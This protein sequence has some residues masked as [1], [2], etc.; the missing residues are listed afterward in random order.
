VLQLNAF[1]GHSRNAIQWQVW[2]ALLVYLLL[3]YLA[4]LS[5]WNHSF[6]RIFTIVRSVLW[7]R[8]YLMELLRFYG[9]AGG[10]F[11]LIY[12][13]KQAFLPGFGP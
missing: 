11:R 9:T 8:F 10:D 12:T 1:L 4:F 7:S 6:T 5:R 2:T 3:R 13:P